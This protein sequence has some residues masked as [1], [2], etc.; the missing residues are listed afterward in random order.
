MKKTVL[1]LH[2]QKLDSLAKFV[3][4]DQRAM[5]HSSTIALTLMMIA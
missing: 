5:K 3:I 4:I 2:K 1:H